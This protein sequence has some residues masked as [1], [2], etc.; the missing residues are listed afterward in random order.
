MS[1]AVNHNI[2]S[3]LL[4]EPVIRSETYY[5]HLESN[6]KDNDVNIHKLTNYDTWDAPTPHSAH[7]RFP[8]ENILR[9]K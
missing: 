6:T 7:S 2:Y 5:C 3:I 8:Q 1:L 4:I 9:I